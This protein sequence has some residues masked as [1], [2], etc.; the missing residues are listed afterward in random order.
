MRGSRPREPARR[1]H[2]RPR[3]HRR[4]TSVFRVHRHRAVR[5]GHCV[6]EL[7]QRRGVLSTFLRRRRV[8]LGLSLRGPA[9]SGRHDV[10]GRRDGAPRLQ[11]RTA[12]R[13]GRW[14]LRRVPHL[15]ELRRVHA[16]SGLRVV[17]RH[18]RVSRRDAHRPFERHMRRGVGVDEH[19]LSRRRR[20][21]ASERR[22]RREPRRLG[23]SPRRARRD[24]RWRRH[25]RRR[26]RRR[27][28]A[29]R[30]RRVRPAVRRTLVR[31]RRMRRLVR[32]LRLRSHLHRRGRVLAVLARLRRSH[33]RS[34][35]LRR[36]VR[37]LLLW[38]VYRRGA[39]RRGRLHV[40]VQRP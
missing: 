39:L 15:V 2:T 40:G 36:N 6:H 5:R 14:R 26:L 22:L 28:R 31:R 33:V 30:R 1:G 34:R 10:R 29:L 32:P 27:G 35:R 12:H 18:A 25:R 11:R 37:T 16:A 17:W 24:P 38:I 7:G 23:S 9:L 8:V 13:A 21:G 3:R 4:H 19:G 20:R